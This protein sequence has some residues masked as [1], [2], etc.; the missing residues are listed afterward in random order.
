MENLQ[1]HP[2]RFR[3]DFISQSASRLEGIESR[4]GSESGREEPDEEDEHEPTEGS[5]L[6]AHA[7]SNG[8][9]THA[10]HNGFAHKNKPYDSCHDSHNHNQPKEKGSGGHSH[11]DLNMRGVFLH[12]MGDALGNIGVIGSAL[13]IWLT[14]YRW[15]FL[16]DPAISLVITLI[17]LGS[18]IPLCIAASRILLQAVPAGISVDDIKEDIEKLPGI[19]RCHQLHVWQLSDAKVVA[20]VHV[21]VKFDFNNEGSA[22]YMLL[23]REINRC[24]HENGVHSS[25]IQPEFSNDGGSGSPTPN[26]GSKGGSRADSMHGDPEACLLS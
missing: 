2:S 6:L 9:A 20:S 21:R 22:E 11:G 26:E 8:S 15:R 23:A 5:P 7:K 17:I 14:D 13:I 19:L 18:A 10:D 3:Q 4:E 1:I 24:L 16:A 25:T 12:V